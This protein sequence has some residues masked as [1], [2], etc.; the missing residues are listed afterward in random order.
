MFFPAQKNF[1]TTGARQFLGAMAWASAILCTSGA[2]AQGQGDSW[3]VTSQVQAPGMPAGMGRFTSQT[4]QAAGAL[5][6][7][8]I[9]QQPNC[10]TTSFTRSG[11]RIQFAVECTGAQA[12]R[13]Q[14]TIELLSPDAY[15]GRLD[16][17]AQGQAMAVN[18]EGKRVA[19]GNC[20]PGARAST[21]APATAG[22][23]ATANNPVMLPPG[24]NQAQYTALVA[25][26]MAQECS[27]TAQRLKNN[28]R[29]DAETAR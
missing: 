11:S 5:D 27:N 29:F 7:K 2:W 9:P 18:F 14:G 24:M 19:S 20:T 23:P 8:S 28:S 3:E 21:Q 12:G 6:E 22:L 16:V 4:C 10:R 25:G 13:G 1:T 26:A 17:Q 15:R